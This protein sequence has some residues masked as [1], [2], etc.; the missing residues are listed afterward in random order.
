MK[1]AHYE[2]GLSTPIKSI[3]FNKLI[4]NT[5]ETDEQNMDGMRR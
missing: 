4:Y 1:T 3:A 2:F 5:S